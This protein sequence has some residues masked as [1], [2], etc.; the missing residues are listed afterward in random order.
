MSDPAAHPVAGGQTEELYGVS[1]EQVEALRQALAG[2]DAALS[3]RLALELHTADLA[4][5]IEHLQP[6]ER[7]QLVEVLGTHIDPELLTLLD[8]PVRDDVIDQMGTEDV[9]AAVTELDHDDAVEVMEHLDEP[10]QE[11]V[12]G[13]LDPR[14]R[15][16]LEE[17][18]GLPEDAAGRLMERN[19][20]A[21][22]SFW[23]VGDT[24]DY[25]RDAADRGGDELPQEF[26]D[27]YIVDPAH[28]P[29]GMIS[30][31]RLLRTRRPVALDQLMATD[32]HTVPMTVDQEDVAHLFRQYDLA[33]APVVEDGG[34]IIG[35]ITVDDI[36]D[37]IHEEAEEDIL[38][39]GGVSHDSDLYRAALETTRSRF[40]WLAINLVTAILA[41]MVIGLF[42]DTIKELVALAVLM[43]IVASMGGNAGTQTL[44]VAVRALAMHELTPTNA[45]RIVGKESLVG[46]I[47]GIL[48]AGV[49][50]I[51]AW[52]WF[53]N[54]AI[55][56]VIAAAMVINL[57]V[58]GLAGVV[59]P[60]CLDRMH[61]DPAIASSVFLTTITDVIGF[62]SF[63]GLAA[64]FLI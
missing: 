56:I 25:L 15:E 60:V 34:R 19:F 5:L 33:S 12:L 44:T 31:S 28:R 45:L 20:V 58:A 41:S 10:I 46:G 11:E 3:E 40:S 48:F 38:R 16:V 1:R 47:N 32:I 36:M 17:S 55:G 27:I 24:I 51:V 53:G 6:A 50:G 21:V 57:A 4:D 39:L 23:T 42:E 9:A 26:F 43:P 29:V 52:V 62:L 22:P 49:I 64:A 13:Q 35:V 18:L 37:V 63:L 14:D 61:V 7:R 59:I 54:P 8:E 30:L 2:N